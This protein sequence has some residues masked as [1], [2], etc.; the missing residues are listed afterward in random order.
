VRELADG[1]H[2]QEDPA[3]R[4]H[5]E[6]DLLALLGGRLDPEQWME[7]GAEHAEKL[8]HAALGVCGERGGNR[9]VAGGR[10][11]GRVERRR[12]RVQAQ[13]GERLVE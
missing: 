13:R 10:A 5:R 9:F 7:D 2:E 8:S 6:D 3:D 1:D 12:I 11:R 4:E